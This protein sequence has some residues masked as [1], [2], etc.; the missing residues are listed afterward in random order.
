MIW[1]RLYKFKGSHFLVLH[2]EPFMYT[3]NKDTG[4]WKD[5]WFHSSIVSVKQSRFKLIGINYKGTK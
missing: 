5:T 3:F 1:N 4:R 2:D